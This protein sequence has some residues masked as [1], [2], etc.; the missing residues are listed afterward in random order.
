[1][2]DLYPSLLGSSWSDLAEPV[3][4]LHAGGASARG[5]FRVRRG[6]N[7][8]A[9][10]IATL[11][12]MPPA[13]EEVAISLK[14]ERGEGGERWIRSFGARPLTS[15]QWQRGGLLVEAMGLVQCLFRLCAEKG[16]LVFQQVGAALGLHRFALP[17]PRWLAPRIEGRAEARLDAVHV[18]VR[19]YAP[20]VGLIVAYE[21]S[22]TF[23]GGG[24]G[25]GVGSSDSDREAIR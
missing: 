4:R 13:A 24:D 15:A 11:L 25:N 2:P 18:D 6:E 14:V 22:V 21:G 5:H 20:L 10:L 9:R 7:L 23:Y 17:L 16:A 1:M 8:A 3:Q 12:R 19:I